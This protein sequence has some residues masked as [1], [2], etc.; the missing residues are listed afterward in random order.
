MNLKNYYYGRDRYD[1]GQ[2]AR[3]YGSGQKLAVE[4]GSLRQPD[5]ILHDLYGKKKAGDDGH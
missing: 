5:R 4:R 2:V 3:I 1:P